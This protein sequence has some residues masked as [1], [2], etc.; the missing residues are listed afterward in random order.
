MN[1]PD[2]L[3]GEKNVAVPFTSIEWR[4]S[5][6]PH[7]RPDGLAARTDATPE[8]TDAGAKPAS[9][10][11]EAPATGTAT[12]TDGSATNQGNP[13]R[14]YIRMSKADLQNAPTFRFSGNESSS[15]ANRASNPGPNAPGRTPQQ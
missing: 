5:A 9:R 4:L 3:L 6:R 13:D 12:G 2:G 15:D 8:P 10:P 14:G 1:S 11:G 7:N